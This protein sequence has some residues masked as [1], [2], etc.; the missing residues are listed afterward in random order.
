M[1]ANAGRVQ[2]QAGNAGVVKSQF[3]RKALIKPSGEEFRFNFKVEELTLNETEKP[4]EPG[5]A[6]EPS[7]AP[8]VNMFKYA[9]SDNAFRFNFC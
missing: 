5:P 3:F 7:I 4:V 1:S 8:A 2:F 6:N 9:P